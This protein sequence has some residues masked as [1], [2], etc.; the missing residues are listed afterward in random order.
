MKKDK[1]V[2]NCKTFCKKELVYVSV[3]LLLM[4]PSRFRH[5]S[6]EE[7]PFNFAPVEFR[8]ASF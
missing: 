3:F 4:F 2:M 5:I 6:F 8:A 7:I 1:E